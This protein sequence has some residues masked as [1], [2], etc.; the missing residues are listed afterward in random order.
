M[1]FKVSFIR[2]T[3][4]FLLKRKSPADVYEHIWE[5]GYAHGI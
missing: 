2:E 1:S 5:R 3:V 4:R